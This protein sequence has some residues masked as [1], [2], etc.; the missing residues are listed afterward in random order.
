MFCYSPSALHYSARVTTQVSNIKS[1]FSVMRTKKGSNGPHVISSC[2]PTH[3]TSTPM[4]VL[5]LSMLLPSLS[6]LQ[7][8]TD[9]LL[10]TDAEECG[11]L[12]LDVAENYMHVRLHGKA[13]PFLEKLVHSETFGQVRI[14]TDGAARAQPWRARPVGAIFDTM[15][16]TLLGCNV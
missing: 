6:P 12:Y 7:S 5:K 1:V 9:Q 2:P 8:Y 14:T 13:L 11:D 4:E 10:D 16:S 3:A 15:T